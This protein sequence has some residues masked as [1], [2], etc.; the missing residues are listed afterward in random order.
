MT[1]HIALFDHRTRRLTVLTALLVGWAFAGV[2][3]RADQTRVPRVQTGFATY[4]SPRLDGQETASGKAADVD[5]LEAAHRSLPFGSLVQVTNLENGRSVK[6]KI[7]DRGPW[8]ENRREG[9]IIDLSPAAGKRL[10]MKK[11][12]QVRVRVKVLKEGAPQE[13]AREGKKPPQPR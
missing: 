1:T 5:A 13:T 6:V 9:T 8:G 11:D 2:A 4:Y 10:G 3:V 12:G 7:V